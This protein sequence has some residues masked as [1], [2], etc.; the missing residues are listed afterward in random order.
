VRNIVK[1]GRMEPHMPDTHDFETTPVSLND[2]QDTD[3]AVLA[4]KALTRR[5]FLGTG[6]AVGLSAF[7]LGTSALVPVARAAG[8]LDFKQVAANSLDTVTVPEGYSWQVVMKWG[9]ELWSKSKA[10]DQASRGTGES[11]ELAIGD[12]FDGMELFTAGNRSVIAVNNEYTN[13]DLV[14]GNRASKKAENL[15]DVRKSKA[16]HGIT[17]AEIAQQGG[18][19]SVVKDSTYNRR[20]TADTAMD[21]TG[22]AKGHDLLKTAADPSGTKSLG[23]INNCGSGRTPWGTFLTCEENFNGNFGSSD[24]EYKPSAAFAR[25][26]IAAKDN[27][28]LWYTQDPRFDISKN[29]NEPNRF[30]WVV[31]I[32]PMNPNSTPKKRTALGRFKHEN[33]AVVI[34]PSG[35]VVV[36]SGDDERGEFLYKF[37]SDGRYAQGAAANANLLDS[38]KLYVAKFAEDGKGQWIELTPANTGMASQAEVL[39][40]TRQ[41]ASKAGATTMDRPEW[42]AVNPLKAEAYCCLTNNVQRGVRANAGG[43]A[44]PVG[45]VNPRKENNYG[46]IVRW[47]PANNDHAAAAFTW[48]LYVVAGNPNVATDAYAGSKNVT[49]QNTFNSPDGLMFD[50]TG[51]LWIQTDGNYSNDKIY[52]GQ[53][54]NQ[55]LVGDPVSGEIRRFL[56]GPRQCEIT[57]ITW[58]GDRKTMFIGVQHP[59]EDGGDS[60]FPDGGTTVARS[61]V[62]AITKNDGSTIG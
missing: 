11:Q 45:G 2:S 23:T 6:A 43:D 57:G 54:N 38:G 19:W 53:G 22:P 59:G 15:D 44:Q 60:H 8:K 4:D 55:M 50:T 26:G 16:G 21:I 12:N 30:G 33:C 25:Y 39:I 62:I 18:K 17:I 7:V 61:A 35:Q 10:F 47:I 24:P 36:Y 28:Y 13:T 49:K 52:A 20:I 46:Q 41:A 27:G 1:I 40:H 37:V 56:V 9:D 32:D 51:L 5:S 48:D 29:P 42:V 14:H 3:F 58:S 34:A 31:E